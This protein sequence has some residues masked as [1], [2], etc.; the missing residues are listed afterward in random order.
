MLHAI[1]K[2]REEYFNQTR[3]GY[4]FV[5]SEYKNLLEVFSL[6]FKMVLTS[7]TTR[8]FAIKLHVLRGMQAEVVGAYTR[9]MCSH[10]RRECVRRL[11]TDETRQTINEYV[12]PMH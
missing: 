10:D 11:S 1:T 5:L 7:A 8:E 12:G 2:Y 3:Q 9:G 4:S 6:Y